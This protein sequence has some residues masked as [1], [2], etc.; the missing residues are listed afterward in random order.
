MKTDKLSS[1]TT[2][3]L[4]SKE[5]YG[6]LKNAKSSIKSRAKK[7]RSPSEIKMAKGDATQKS[8]KSITEKTGD[9]ETSKYE[10]MLK[11]VNREFEL[12]MKKNAEMTVE[13]ANLEIKHHKVQEQLN[14]TKRELETELKRKKNKNDSSEAEKTELQ[15]LNQDMNQTILEQNEEIDKL[16]RAKFELENKLLRSDTVSMKS[17]KNETELREKLTELISKY[18]ILDEQARDK[19]S[20]L[21][22]ANLTIEALKSELKNIQKIEAA[23]DCEANSIK[24]ERDELYDLSNM[25]KEKL[26]KSGV[27]LK[28]VMSECEDLQRER[29]II[30]NNYDFTKHNEE[31]LKE[32]NYSLKQ[33]YQR[34]E[35]DSYQL[36]EQL[37]KLNLQQ[38][39]TIKELLNIESYMVNNLQDW[40]SV[41]SRINLIINN[42]KLNS[43]S[44]KLAARIFSDFA[45]DEI[46][47]V[48]QKTNTALSE[49]HSVNN[50]NF[51][52]A[53]DIKS[54]QIVN[55]IDLSVDNSR[56]TRTRMRQEKI[57]PFKMKPAGLKSNTDTV[58]RQDSVQYLD[59]KRT[60]TIDERFKSPEFSKQ[61]NMMQSGR[62]QDNSSLTNS[63]V[64]HIFLVDK[65]YDSKF[66]EFYISFCIKIGD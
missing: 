50:D 41:K 1:S 23:R 51:F 14:K 55:Q 42:I 64:V 49:Y 12:S 2:K 62:L 25:L 29:N 10:A 60:K 16:K 18:S 5:K 38:D 3:I 30:K 11:K 26:M 36:K 54:N 53:D 40:S 57:D 52:Q 58:F 35:N 47:R 17:N 34:I 56:L 33:K 6:V 4:N 63:E 24:E 31:Q 48:E 44:S 59:R 28:Q 19:D 21:F 32:E 46:E 27:A 65:E 7:Q 22:K 9:T 37:R 43:N 66:N 15:K 45:F 13:L 20:Q 39:D 61:N 8:T